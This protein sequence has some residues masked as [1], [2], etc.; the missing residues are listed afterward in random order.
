[1]VRRMDLSQPGSL[2][3]LGTNS[4]QILVTFYQVLTCQRFPLTPLQGAANPLSAQHARR[5]T[6]TPQHGMAQHMGLCSRQHPLQSI[7][8]QL[9]PC[10][11]HSH[12]SQRSCWLS[13]RDARAPVCGRRVLEASRWEP[14]SGGLCSMARTGRLGPGGSEQRDTLRGAGC[15]TGAGNGQSRKDWE[16]VAKSLA[17]SREMAGHRA[18]ALALMPSSGLQRGCTSYRKPSFPGGTCRAPELPAGGAGRL[19][20]HRGCAQTG[21]S[22][23]W[24][25]SSSAGTLVVGRRGWAGAAHGCWARG[26]LLPV[27]WGSSCSCP[28]AWF[29]PPIHVALA[30]PQHLQLH[31]T[32]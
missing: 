21:A 13:Q 25:H 12:G 2:P 15:G 5:P 24:L 32:L 17:Q 22:M 23:G 27:L 20:M 29:S 1:M 19:Q 16:E 31:P 6:A 11:W 18:A 9:S 10:S 14:C 28:T 3:V 26:S 4:G 7:P 8:L 30:P